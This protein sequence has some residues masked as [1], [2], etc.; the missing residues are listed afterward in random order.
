MKSLFFAGAVTAIMLGMSATATAQGKLT[1]ALVPKKMNNPFFDQARD[2]CKKA[3]KELAGRVECYYIGP[4]EHGGGEEQ[5]QVV[6]DLITK[7]VH[8][9]AVSPSNAPAM[10]KVL[11]RA[12]AAH[13]PVITWDSD[14]L[15]KD[16]GLR[17]T[18]VG[19]KNYDVGVQLARMVQEIKPN[20]GEVCIQS[21]GPAA[22]NHNERMKG[23]RDTLSG[24]MAKEPPG[25]RLTGQNGWS[26]PESC[27]LYTNDDFPVAV[28]QMADIWARY[29]NL[30]AF[31]PTGG[32][33]QLLP[34]AYRQIAQKY[35]DRITSKHTAL[36]VA[37]TLPVQMQILKD[38]L[39]HG[40]VGQRPFAMGYK[41]IYLLKDLVDGKKVPDPIYTGLDLCTPRNVDSCLTK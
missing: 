2:G 21:G 35:K 5:V 38:G 41:A 26:E 18:Y 11:E 36:V 3:E 9:I 20:G 34:Q 13:I 29:P 7:K 27:P 22:T 25:D 14:L 1:L 8:G 10:A 15:D 16:K 40:Q 31:I 23:I 17:A 24:K 19:T 32:A 28:Q 12:K 4:G 33:P 37:N 6:Q 30:T 39:S